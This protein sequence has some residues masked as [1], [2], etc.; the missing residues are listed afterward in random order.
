M[1]DDDAFQL[2]STYVFLHDGGQATRMPGGPA[3]WATIGERKLAEGWLVT[4]YTMHEDWPHWEMHPEGEELVS[5]ISGRV[6][7]LLDDGARQWQVEMGS[8]QTIVNQRGTWHRALVHEPSDM[9]FVTAGR[10]TQ[11]RP[12]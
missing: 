10:N 7:M 8:G 3:F 12:K 4:R 5:L 1:P 2:D 9:L 11:H 6:T